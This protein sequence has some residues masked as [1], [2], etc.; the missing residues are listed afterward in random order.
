MYEQLQEQSQ[1]NRIKGQ[2]DEIRKKM[3]EMTK[4]EI[5]KI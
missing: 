3:N 2:L 1:D 5:Q 4:G